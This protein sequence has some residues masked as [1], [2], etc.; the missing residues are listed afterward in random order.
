MPLYSFKFLQGCDGGRGGFDL[1]FY[2]DE[3][4]ID[5]AKQYANESTVEVWR[6]DQLVATVG[7][8]ISQRKAS[9]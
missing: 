2:H 7:R 4:A 9:H 6:G 3:P 1:D 8:K 5:H